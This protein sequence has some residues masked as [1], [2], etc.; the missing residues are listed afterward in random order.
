MRPRRSRAVVLQAA[1]CACLACGSS[2]A[3]SQDK[4]KGSQRPRGAPR[5]RV[6]AQRAPAPTAVRRILTS[7]RRDMVESSAAAMST[8][9]PGILFTVNDAGN[10]PIL[11]ALDT[12][13]A[14]RGAWRIVGARNEDWEAATTG[15]CEP[16]T[17]PARSCIYVGDVGDNEEQRVGVAIYRVAEPRATRGGTLDTLRAEARLAFRYADGPHDVEAMVA[18]PDG[19]ILLITKRQRAG[20]NR[21]LRPALVFGIPLSAWQGD[22][23]AVAQLVD[24]LPIVPGSA[25]LRTITDAALSPDAR[26]LAVRTYGEVYL[27]ATDSASGRARRDVPPAVCDISGIEQGFGEGVAFLARPGELLLTREGRGAPMHV[28]TCPLPT[29]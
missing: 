7:P 23:T 6:T 4:G 15:P 17:I 18:A 21:T 5:A 22:G 10:A 11:F 27:F 16:R 29:R 13:G 20:S 19:T 14:D 28:I 26:H 9:Q 24:S 2:E 8:T 12:T 1:V 3:G 25:R